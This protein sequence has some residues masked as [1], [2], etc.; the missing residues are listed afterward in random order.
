MD[1]S[2]AEIPSDLTIDGVSLLP[3]LER[4]EGQWAD[5]MLF[6]QCSRGMTPH[7]YQNCAVI[8]QRFKMLGYPNSFEDR[9]LEVLRD[10]T[11]LELYDISADPG[12]TKNVADQYP[13]ELEKL[14]I[15]Y[16]KWFDDVKSTRQFSPGVIYI[17][18]DEEKTTYLC[19]YQDASYIDKKPTGWPVNIMHQGEYEVTINRGESLGKG[20]LCIQYD[21]VYVAQ[22]LRQ[23][24]NRAIFTLPEGEVKLNV[25]V[26][27]DGK[28]YVP[29]PDED[30]ISDVR[31]TL[32]SDN[33]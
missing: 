22:P 30:L 29:R 26:K 16:D 19:C 33:I 31:I 24:E 10:K 12:E 9:N 28:K 1:I 25:W 23:G 3:L 13:E 5:R 21:S 2:G 32:I 20:Q 17:G 14:R 6:M 15:A 7:R 18:S 27:E 11:G 8:L 4:K